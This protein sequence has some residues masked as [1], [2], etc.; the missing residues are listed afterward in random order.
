MGIAYGK[1]RTR[2][3]L[4]DFERVPGQGRKPPHP[5]IQRLFKMAQLKNFRNT[6]QL[7]NIL[8]NTR[9]K[10]KSLEH[11]H[12][13]ANQLNKQRQQNNSPFIENFEFSVEAREHVR[14][15]ACYRFKHIGKFSRQQ[16]SQQPRFRAREV[17]EKA[18]EKITQIASEHLISGNIHHIKK[19]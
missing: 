18:L 2:I 8:E 16:T 15:Y 11:L 1:R 4:E 10:G 3:Q 9:R 19:D 14:R 7:S 6:M 5:E 17:E 12:S 13:T